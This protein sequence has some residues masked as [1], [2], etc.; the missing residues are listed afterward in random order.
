MWRL[1]CTSCDADDL[2]TLQPLTACPHC[3]GQWLEPTYDYAALGA[4]YPQTVRNRRYTMWRYRELLPLLDDHHKITMGEGGTP[5]LHLKHLG[6]MVGHRHLYLKDERQGPTGSFKDRQASLALSVM[7]E[8]GVREAVVASTGNVAIAY[9]AYATQ[10]GIKLWA[11]LTSA[12]PNDKMREV[13]LYGTEVVKVTAT[14]DRTKEV[15][16]HFAERKGLHLDRGIRSIAAREAMKTIAFE[17]CEELG[18]LDAEE[19]VSDG[20]WRAPDWYIQA[21]SGGMGP[22]GVL[23][24]FQEL[25]EMGIID[26]IPK[27][28]S[29]QTTGCAPMVEAWEADSPT[30]FN[31][32]EPR[33]RITTV[34][35]GS[36]GVAY[37]VLYRAA[38]EYGGTFIAVRDEDAFRA[39]HIMAKMDGISM[40]PAAAM[41]CAA[42]IQMVRDGII[43]PDETVAICCSGHTFPVEKHLLDEDWTHDLDLSHEAQAVTAAP[44]EGILQSLEGLSQTIRRVAI[45]EDDPASALLVRRILQAQGNYGILEAND[46]MAGME[47][48]RRE[49]PDLVLLD[50]MMP[51]MDGFTVVEQMKA[52]ETLH[53]IPIIVI[54]AATLTAAEKARLQ[55]KV[56]ATLRKGSFVDTELIEVVER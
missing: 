52:D 20:K 49:K 25:H 3:G 8:H 33:T 9:S 32:A 54:T 21:V 6:W 42:A 51:G 13:A 19:G 31:V 45:I 44:S 35:T 7:K 4:N 37:E 36:P 24:G 48:I 28:A 34:A 1:R 29:V 53:D 18:L 15:A 56:R 17:L 55:G 30:P 39:M 11:F 14:Y 12:V 22:V 26:K 46:G 47:L 43:Q 16:A 5:L 40:E 38:K 2:T 41:A 50:L 27:I 10:A 23:K